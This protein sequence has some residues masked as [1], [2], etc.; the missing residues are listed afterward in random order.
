MCGGGVQGVGLLGGECVGGI[1]LLKSQHSGG[2]SLNARSAW[3]S[4]RS[5]IDRATQRNPAS[6]NKTKQPPTKKAP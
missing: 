6:K 1:Q 4:L 3:S 5:R 2:R